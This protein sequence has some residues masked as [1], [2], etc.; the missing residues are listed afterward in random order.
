MCLELP[1]WLLNFQPP[2]DSVVCTSFEIIDDLLALEEEEKFVVDVGPEE[3]D[4]EIGENNHTTVTIVDNDGT[5]ANKF[6]V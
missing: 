2:G 4:V 6:V 5:T 3:G 1:T